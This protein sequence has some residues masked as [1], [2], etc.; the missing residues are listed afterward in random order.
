[1]VSPKEREGKGFFGKQIS[2]KC[3]VQSSFFNT[4]GCNMAPTSFTLFWLRRTSVVLYDQI[5][6]NTGEEFIFE[7]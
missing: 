5:K 7:R 4:K 2:E 1:M 3:F 6:L